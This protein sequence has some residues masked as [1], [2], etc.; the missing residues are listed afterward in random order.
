MADEIVT[1]HVS[2][3][4]I[5]PFISFSLFAIQYL[6]CNFKAV[7]LKADL[8]LLNNLLLPFQVF[9]GRC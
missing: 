1:I 2:L 7:K 8:Q 5:F 4:F 6:S 9:R 3:P